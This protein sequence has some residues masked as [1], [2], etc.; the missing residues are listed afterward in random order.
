[1]SSIYYPIYQLVGWGLVYSVLMVTIASQP[2]FT[3]TEYFF[4]AVLVG[5]TGLFSHGLRIIYKR[6]LKHRAISWQML[7]WV[8]GSVTGGLFAG[9]MLW[10]AVLAIAGTQWYD[11]IPPGQAMVFFQMIYWSN[12]MN[13]M[14]MLLLWSACYVAIV[15]TRMLRDAEQ[16]LLKGQLD[17]LMQQLN[18]H[19]LFNM[20]NNIRALIIED[21]SKAREALTQLADMLRYNLQ[22]HQQTQVPLCDELEIVE[23]Y[24]A[25]NKIQYEERLQYHQEIDVEAY[26]ALIPRLLLQQ[27][28]ENAIKHG[29]ASDRL[30]GA[31]NLNVRRVEEQ[32]HITVTNPYHPVSSHQEALKSPARR[33][34]RANGAGIGLANSQS[35]LALMY[36]AKARIELACDEST[37]RATL[38]IVLPFR[39]A[40]GD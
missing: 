36:G 30:G 8:G 38:T 25:L 20:L 35:R 26:R 32:L 10:V 4:G 29:I 33:R 19:F 13:M 12:S 17:L 37:K 7:Y 18:P 14:F 9:L 28:I 3:R 1:M 27:S 34:T 2:I 5:S 21:P 15:R 6:L 16:A 40:E 22:A 24:V 23:Q 39:V 31:L 11:P